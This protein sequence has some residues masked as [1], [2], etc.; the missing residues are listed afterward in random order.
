[1]KLHSEGIELESTATQIRGQNGLTLNFSANS[2]ASGMDGE[3]LDDFEEGTFVPTVHSGVTNP[4]LSRAKGSYVKIGRQVLWQ[5]HIIVSGGTANG[6]QLMF[7]GL[8][9]TSRNDANQAYGGAWLNYQGNTFVKGS[10]I[11]FHTGINETVIIP[12]LGVI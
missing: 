7:G 5:S 11:S 4:S 6:D 10:E 3:S 8:P 9:F 12:Q 1:M 2:N